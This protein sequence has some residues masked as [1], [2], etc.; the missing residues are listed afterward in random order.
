MENTTCLEPL[1]AADY[2]AAAQDLSG[3]VTKAWMSSQKQ[4]V[5]P[6]QLT[7]AL[8]ERASGQKMLKQVSS[9][10]EPADLR[11]PPM[12][13]TAFLNAEGSKPTLSFQLEESAATPELLEFWKI[14]NQLYGPKGELA[15]AY[16]KHHKELVPGALPTGLAKHVSKEGV[17][18]DL[19]CEAGVRGRFFFSPAKQGRGA[20]GNQ[21]W[22]VFKVYLT[23]PKGEMTAKDREAVADAFP[24]DH[25]LRIALESANCALASN[26]FTVAD[27]KPIADWKHGGRLQWLPI[28]NAM[29]KQGKKGTFFKGFMSLQ[30]SVQA[31][32]VMDNSLFTTNVYLN[33]PGAKLYLTA[34]S[35]GDGPSA[36]V[37]DE[38]AAF[39]A[40]RG[41][42]RKLE[43]TGDAD[44]L[45]VKLTKQDKE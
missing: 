32:W 2:S 43:Q 9:S 1:Q 25:P 45:P 26:A 39:F 34:A 21:T 10:G 17:L 3:R 8:M 44:G 18:N 42:K 24:A 12:E 16:K 38:D 7:F 36:D 35:R 31:S 37:T 6:D 22:L 41:M 40:S 29:S 5:N 27:G 13:V 30:L 4:F 15:K 33:G 19:S 14:V 28:L 20:D 11:S 23:A